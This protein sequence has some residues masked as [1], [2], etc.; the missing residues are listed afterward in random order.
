MPKDVQR[1][2][3]QEAK[4]AN[5]ARLKDST[6]KNAAKTRMKGKNRATNRHRKRQDNI[7][8]VRSRARQT[9]SN[10]CLTSACAAH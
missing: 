5:A 1:E 9:M 6:D 7:V 4:A 10:G 3:A 8:E 2:R